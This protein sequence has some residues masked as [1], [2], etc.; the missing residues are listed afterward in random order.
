MTDLDKDITFTTLPVRVYLRV[1]IPFKHKL[2]QSFRKLDR[3]VG[4][5]KS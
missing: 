2:I 5:V 3:N 4:Q 1:G